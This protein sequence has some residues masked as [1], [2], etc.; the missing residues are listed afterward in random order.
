MELVEGM[1]RGLG[2]N[3]FVQ[4]EMVRVYA[5]SERTRGQT[6]WLKVEVL[7]REWTGVMDVKSG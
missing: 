1:G 7:V 5:L 6:G 4:V 3:S 2:E